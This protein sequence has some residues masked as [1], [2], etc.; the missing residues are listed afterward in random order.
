MM[1]LN[2]KHVCT[3]VF[4]ELKDVG[5]SPTMKHMSIL[6]LSVSNVTQG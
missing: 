6:Q 5:A 3:G 2:V 1:D 4:T